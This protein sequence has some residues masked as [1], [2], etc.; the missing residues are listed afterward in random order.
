MKWENW[1]IFCWECKTPAEEIENV[2][3]ISAENLPA[4]Q[5]NLSGDYAFVVAD[6]GNVKKTNTGA[7]ILFRTKIRESRELALKHI[8]A[9]DYIR[10]RALEVNSLY[11]Y[12]I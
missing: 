9:D 1:K 3:N 11:W 2:E 4:E 8:G 10:K 12:I 6:A 7:Y 5:K